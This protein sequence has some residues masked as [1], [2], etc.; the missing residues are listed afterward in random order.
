[1]IVTLQPYILKYSTE[2]LQKDVWQFLAR[3][4]VILVIS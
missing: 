4:L 2:V 1:M 3:P